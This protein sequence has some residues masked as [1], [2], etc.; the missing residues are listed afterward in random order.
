MTDYA[1]EQANEIE[2]LESIYPEE[3]T[4]IQASPHHVFQVPIT[5]QSDEVSICAA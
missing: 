2:A 3:F 5:A 1:E 4:L